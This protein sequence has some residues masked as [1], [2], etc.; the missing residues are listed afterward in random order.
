MRACRAC[1][2]FMS[3][4]NCKPLP[5]DMR[6]TLRARYGFKYNTRCWSAEYHL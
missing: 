6:R 3:N 2:Q 5:Q 1:E 4:G